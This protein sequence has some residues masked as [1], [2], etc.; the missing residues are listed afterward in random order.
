MSRFNVL[1]ICLITGISCCIG[2]VFNLFWVNKVPFVTP[3]KVEIY[4]KKDIPTLSLDETRKKFD[5]QG[6]I[7]L[8]AREAVD[9]EA[10]HIKDALNLP[11]THF[12]L[13]YPKMKSMLPRDADIIVYCEGEECG[14]SLHLAEELIGLQYTN[15]KVFLGGWVDWNKA[16]YPAE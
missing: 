6:V 5:Q 4:A 11:V 8:D 3:S 13:Y 14:A 7:F 10:K 16:G 15:I 12:G 9:Y 2:I 1:E